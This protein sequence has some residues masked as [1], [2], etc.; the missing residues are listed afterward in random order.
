VVDDLVSIVQYGV[1]R[2]AIDVDATVERFRARYET[3][4]PRLPAEEVKALVS[5]MAAWP[6]MVSLID[7]AAPYGFLIY[8]VNDVDPVMRMAGNKGS[9]VSYLMGN[10]TIAERM[11]R[12]EPAVMLYAP[13][14]TAIWASA[15]GAGRFSFDKPSD[16]FASFGN[17]AIT[18][19]GLELNRKLAALLEHLEVAVP[20][21]LLA[22]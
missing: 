2:F 3:A 21:S 17:A 1:T 6:E 10:H 9:C 4:V 20:D 11:F 14:H 15:D 13:L 5:T 12:H 8:G 18:Q 7:E 22:S 19:V 16:Q